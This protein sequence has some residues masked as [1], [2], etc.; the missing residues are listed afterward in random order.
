MAQAAQ[1]DD[2]GGYTRFELELEVSSIRHGCSCRFR[3]RR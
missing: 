2:Y 3:S 1:R